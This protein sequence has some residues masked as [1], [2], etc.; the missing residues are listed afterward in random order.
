[1][2]FFEIPL[3]FKKKSALEYDDKIKYN[4]FQVL[5]IIIR[6]LFSELAFAKNN[7]IPNSYVNKFKL[8]GLTFPLSF[9]G[10]QKLI[11]KINICQ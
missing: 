5:Y 9:N 3:Y 4:K 6:H 2:E 11:K 7:Q 10:L 1:M 8:K